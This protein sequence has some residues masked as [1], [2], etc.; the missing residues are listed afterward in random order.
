VKIRDRR[1]FATTRVNDAVRH[2]GLDWTRRRYDIDLRSDT[3]APRGGMRAAM[4]AAEV[5]D[6][7]YGDDPLS[8]ACKH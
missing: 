3:Y 7:V 1:G 5:G 8:I 4:A 6:D 2:G